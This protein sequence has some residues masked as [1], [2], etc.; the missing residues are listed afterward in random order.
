MKNQFNRIE[1]VYVAAIEYEMI[2]NIFTGHSKNT[3]VPKGEQ[4]MFEVVAGVTRARSFCG[5]GR[6]DIAENTAELK[7][8]TS[9]LPVCAKC[10]KNGKPTQEVHGRDL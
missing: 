1:V 3:A 9:G 10:A 2:S 6:S 7:S 8:P 5:K 4:H